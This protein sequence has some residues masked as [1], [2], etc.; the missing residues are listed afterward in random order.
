MI[1]ENHLKGYGFNTID[2]Y[3][4]YI[5]DSNGNGQRTQAISLFISLSRQQKKD[6]LK[7]LAQRAYEEKEALCYDTLMKCIN[8]IY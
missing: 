2:E 4:Q 7:Q 5:I 1:K 6:F 8:V 3:Y